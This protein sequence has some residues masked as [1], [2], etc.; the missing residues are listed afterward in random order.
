MGSLYKQTSTKLLNAD[1]PTL[2]SQSSYRCSDYKLKGHLR[3]HK[4]KTLQNRI[5]GCR[6]KERRVVSDHHK[7][8]YKI[9]NIS[10]GYA[11]DQIS[12]LIFLL[13]NTDRLMLADDPSSFDTI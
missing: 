13:Q 10:R 11:N 1:P 9:G 8:Q 7:S 5:A 3:I 2:P 6:I 12:L 4:M